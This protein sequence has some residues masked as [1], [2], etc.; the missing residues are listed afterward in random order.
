MKSIQSK[1]QNENGQRQRI[2]RKVGN[3]VAAMLGVSIIIVVVLCISIF[4][5]LVMNML[6]EQCVSGTNMLAYE[7]Q[8]YSGPED[9]TQ[10]LDDLKRQ[11]DCEFT[12]FNGDERAYT[13][14]LQEG[15]R[16]VGT[17]LSDELAD[18]VLQQGQAYV[19]TAEILGVDHL[20]SYVPTKDAAGKVNGLIFE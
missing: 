14:I 9:K 3:L 6:E 18:I 13:T 8:D 11:T 15:Q 2:G 20:C 17:K 10:L 16:A 12:I 7:L 4:Y 5:N 19:G 1:Q